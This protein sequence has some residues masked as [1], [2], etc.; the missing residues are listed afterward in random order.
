MKVEWR[1]EKEEKDAGKSG[2]RKVVFH[3]RFYAFAF[4]R[5]LSIIGE[6]KYIRRYKLEYLKAI[7][8]FSI[9]FSKKNILANFLDISTS[10]LSI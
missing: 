5:Y 3:R 10:V 4:Y 1:Q 9:R 6:K 2:N 7:T 8:R